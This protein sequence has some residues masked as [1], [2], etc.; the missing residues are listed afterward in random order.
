MYLN[1]LFGGGVS[2]NVYIYKAAEIGN[3]NYNMEITG[4]AIYSSGMYVTQEGD[5]AFKT[6][7][8]A[9]RQIPAT[10]VTPAWPWADPSTTPMLETT[11]DK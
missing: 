8:V 10:T 6:G 3:T 5:N 1:Q 7:G 11:I 9:W 4:I 2:R